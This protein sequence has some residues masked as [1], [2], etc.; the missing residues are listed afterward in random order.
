MRR[1]CGQQGALWGGV[2]GSGQAGAAAAGTEGA[3][4]SPRQL[5]LAGSLRLTQGAPRGCGSVPAVRPMSER[6]QIAVWAGHRMTGCSHMLWEQGL[7][8][9]RGSSERGE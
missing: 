2:W 4:P 1:G 7:C 9:G 6:S 5:E 8:E 3:L